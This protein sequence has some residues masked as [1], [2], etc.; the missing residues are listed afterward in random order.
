MIQLPARRAGAPAGS[1]EVRALVGD[2]ESLVIASDTRLLRAEAADTGVAEGQ[3]GAPPS[4][5]ETEPRLQDLH[6]AAIA[7]LSL[8]R[9]RIESMQSRV[10]KRGWL[11]IVSVRGE[12][13]TD[14]DWG[15]DRDQTFTSGSLHNLVDRAS[16]R[17]DN[18][19][20]FTSRQWSVGDELCK[21]MAFD[22]LHAKE[23]SSIDFADFVDRH[24]VWMLQ[25][26]GRRRFGQE[27]L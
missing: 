10:G 14:K 12:Y 25:T 19:R 16:D 6:R 4:T 13:G 7:H 11:P 27:S 15:T 9:G 5:W 8:S 17:G 22:Q 26:R 2:G 1:A 21:R 18:L 24:N 23:R 20:S 3:A